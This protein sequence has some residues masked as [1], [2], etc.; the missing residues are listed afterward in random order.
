MVR[1]TICDKLSI[2]CMRIVKIRQWLIEWFTEILSNIANFC[3]CF[4][5]SVIAAGIILVKPS[6][7]K[8]MEK[9][10]FILTFCFVFV[11]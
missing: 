11:F 5:T 3:F 7:I 9:C 2:K 10:F 6:G 4:K 8:T 1:H